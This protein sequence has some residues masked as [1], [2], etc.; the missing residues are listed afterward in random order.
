V[1]RGWATGVVPAR[2]RTASG[3]HRIPD[4]ARFVVPRPGTAWCRVTPPG[5]ITASAVSIALSGQ[6]DPGT[7]R[8]VVHRDGP[9]PLR[10]E[11]RSLFG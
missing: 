9:G 6:A 4:A 10:S 1:T 7:F 3:Q 11:H 5:P 8:A 2:D